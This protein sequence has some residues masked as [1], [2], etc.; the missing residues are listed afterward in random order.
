MHTRV[1][2]HRLDSHYTPFS[3][4]AWARLLFHSEFV[5]SFPSWW[6]LGLRSMDIPSLVSPVSI[7]AHVVLRAQT[8]TSDSLDRGWARRWLATCC[9]VTYLTSLCL[10]FP[11]CEVGNHNRISVL[12]LCQGLNMRIRCK[13]LRMRVARRKLSITVS[14]WLLCGPWFAI[15]FGAAVHS[16]ERGSDLQIPNSPFSTSTYRWG[17]GWPPRGAVLAAL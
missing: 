4:G 16:L 14:C 17:R 7:Q 1:C 15:G 12:G 6:P 8:L 3:K 5:K 13:V 10:N 2:V 11:V 9:W